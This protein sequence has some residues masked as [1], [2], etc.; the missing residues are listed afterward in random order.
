MDT[1]RVLGTE[2]LLRN[3]IGGIRA[4]TVGANGT[5][6]LATSNALA[7]LAPAGR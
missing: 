4:M 7:T 1:T 3:T 6:Y 5:V 2:R